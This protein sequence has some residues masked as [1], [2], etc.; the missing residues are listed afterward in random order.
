MLKVSDRAAY[1]HARNC[2]DLGGLETVNNKKVKFGYLY[3]GTNMDGTS[4]E[5]KDLL[6]NEMRVGLDVDLRGQGEGTTNPL[7]V[8]YSLGNYQ[9]SYNDLTNAT[10]MKKTIGDIISFINNNDNKAAYIH[11]RIGSDRTGYVCMLVEALLG[12]PLWACDIDYELT[13]FAS[14]MTSG[15]RTRNSG[16][17]SDFR[18]K[19]LPSPNDPNQLQ[20]IV[21][22]YVINDLGISESEVNKFINKLVE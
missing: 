11:C 18:R 10:K 9:A 20:S 14:S 17:N 19:F 4:S 22:D 21:K 6:R 3:R 12:V 2:R 13:S 15:N 1:D 5:E 8:T 7:N 16:Q